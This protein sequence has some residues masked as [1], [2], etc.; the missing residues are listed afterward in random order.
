MVCVKKMI[1]LIILS[2]IHFTLYITQVNDNVD[3][4]INITNKFYSTIINIHNT[5]LIF[6]FVLLCSL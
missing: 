1:D 4:V 6:E 5:Q 3:M 2:T